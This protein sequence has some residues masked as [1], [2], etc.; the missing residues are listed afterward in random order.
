MGRPGYP[1]E[2]R[3]KVL[4]PRRGQ[5]RGQHR[6]RS[7]DQPAASG[8]PPSLAAEAALA[9]G[10]D[11]PTDPNASRSIKQTTSRCR[12]STTGERDDGDWSL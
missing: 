12:A 9:S 8:T 6:S 11:F 5:E 10:Q 1:A 7:R 2:F 3:R 4:D